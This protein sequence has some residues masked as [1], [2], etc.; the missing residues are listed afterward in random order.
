MI[1]PI[2]GS[3]W[4]WTKLTGEGLLL[5]VVIVFVILRVNRPVDIVDSPSGSLVM[6]PMDADV[7]YQGQGLP[8]ARSL[9]QEGTHKTPAGRIKILPHVLTDLPYKN[10][11]ETES[12]VDHINA[13][14]RPDP[15]WRFR[16]ERRM[17]HYKCMSLSASTVR[18]WLRLG[19]RVEMKPYASMLNGQPEWGLNP[20][21]L[22]SLYYL[23]AENEPDL[24]PL[25]GSKH[26]DPV[27]GVPVPRGMRGFI[28]LLID[29]PDGMRALDVSLPG[30]AYEWQREG[31]LPD[32][33]AT[34]I[35][36]NIVFESPFHVVV[37][38]ISGRVRDAIDTNGILYAGIRVR[39]SASGGV[40]NRS[41]IGD[42]PL[43]FMTGHAV[44]IV[45][46]IEQGEDLYFVYRETF[47]EYDTTSSYGGP[48][49]RVY[50]VFGF[51][52]VYSFQPPRQAGAGETQR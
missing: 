28:K 31:L 41:R 27:A 44:A 36:R 42:V 32:Y 26:Y 46:W 17:G 10:N 38:E 2:D 39:F 49:Y 48:A 47:G 15:P 29:P 34:E 14:Y 51:S 9:L 25:T 1:R 6:P 22:D 33:R 45:G 30:V 35:F 7:W 37:Q 16:P 11:E 20:K 18:D 23:H 24:F 12:W 19:E 4:I 50:P 40:I 52:E 5:L 3:W 13:R 21:I 8:L 43:P